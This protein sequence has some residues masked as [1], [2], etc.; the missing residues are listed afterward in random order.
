M[1]F[2]INVQPIFTSHGQTYTYLAL[3]SDKTKSASFT[4]KAFFVVIPGLEEVCGAVLSALYDRPSSSAHVTKYLHEVIT[5][6]GPDL[7][8]TVSAVSAGIKVVAVCGWK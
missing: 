8:E 2:L 6:G 3:Q 1:H 4:S 7:E 5:S